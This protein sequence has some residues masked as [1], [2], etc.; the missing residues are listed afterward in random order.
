MERT[1][2]PNLVPNKWQITSLVDAV[3]FTARLRINGLIDVDDKT[4]AW[5]GNNALDIRVVPD[6]TREKKVKSLNT[7]QATVQILLTE[8]LPSQTS[9]HIEDY[10]CQPLCRRHV[11]SVEDRSKMAMV[12]G[13]LMPFR[14][15]ANVVH[16]TSPESLR[17]VAYCWLLLSDVCVRGSTTF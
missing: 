16:P 3:P 9:Y 17:W 12:Q 10:V 1:K 4:R 2:M 13:Q 5:L 15:P 14:D 7:V 11:S 8:N 6:S